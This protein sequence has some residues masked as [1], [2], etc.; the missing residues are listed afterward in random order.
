MSP[1]KNVRVPD[2]TLEQ[3][4]LRELPADES[5]RIE[6]RA[7]REPELAAR[8]AALE[9][10]TREILRQHPPERFAADLRE[11]TA[12]ARR[13]EPARDALRG[14]RRSFLFAVPALAGAAVLTL[15]LA[16]SVDDRAGNGLPGEDLSGTRLKGLEP[17]LVAYVSDEN[18]T[19][20]VADGETVP[21]GSRVQLS[22]I[23]A[24]ASYGVVISIDDRGATTL[25]FP[26][27]PNGSTKLVPGTETPLP[28][29]FALDGT[30]GFERF[31]LITSATPI[32]MSDVL[33]RVHGPETLNLADGMSE[34]RLTLFKKPERA[35]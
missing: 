22:Y 26:T 14:R 23:A 25:H 15:F 20:A 3:Y 1:E 4:V 10:S 16:R 18:G 32:D 17:H 24:D 7:R 6:S 27:T 8:I 30:P 2:W 21:P 35:R 19:H 9:E 31:F 5:R 33:A 11:R 12:G 13:P 29:S 28:R 34:H